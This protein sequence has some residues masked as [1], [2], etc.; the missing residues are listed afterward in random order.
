MKSNGNARMGMLTL[1]STTV[2]TLLVGGATVLLGGRY[3]E[4]AWGSQEFGKFVLIVTLL[5]N[6]IAAVLYVLWFAITRADD[7]A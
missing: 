4:R 1:Y 7:Q 2:L 5:P 3:L 6:L